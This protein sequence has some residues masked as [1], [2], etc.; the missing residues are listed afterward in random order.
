MQCSHSRREEVNQA[1]RELPHS[2][3]AGYPSEEVARDARTDIE[4]ILSG[5]TGIVRHELIK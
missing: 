4:A 5:I 2:S 3:F 1:M